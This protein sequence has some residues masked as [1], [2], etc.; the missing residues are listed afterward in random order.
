MSDLQLS[1]HIKAIDNLSLDDIKFSVTPRQL[2][3]SMTL[4]TNLEQ[5]QD[6][7]GKYIHEFKRY[8]CGNN[9]V[10]V[11]SERMMYLRS[12]FYWCHILKSTQNSS[13]PGAS[14]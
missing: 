4:S 11:E 14:L 12:L 2:L 5:T 10:V 9:A 13:R 6:V 8:F 1:K 3:T 7:V